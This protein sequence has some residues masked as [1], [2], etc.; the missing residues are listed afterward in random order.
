M[1]QATN[2]T[3]MAGTL[4]A[5]LDVSSPLEMVRLFRA[6]D[7]EL[8]RERWA[9]EY[10]GL[11]DPAVTSRVQ[12]AHRMIVDVLQARHARRVRT[13]LLTPMARRTRTQLW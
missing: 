9:A 7:E 5:N 6:S 2:Y 10:P 3:E 11:A 13:W 4:T 8:L 12:E 1:A